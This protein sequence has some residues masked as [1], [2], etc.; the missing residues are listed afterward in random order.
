MV[1]TSMPDVD[2]GH[3]VREHLAIPEHQLWAD[4]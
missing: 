2:L 4:V 1:L 3:P